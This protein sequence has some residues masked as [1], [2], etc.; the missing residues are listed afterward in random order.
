[1]RTTKFS[2]ALLLVYAVELFM[3]YFLGL[4]SVIPYF[5][6]IPFY[7]FL[8][9]K[10][11]QINILQKIIYFILF[12]IINLIVSFYSIKQSI[13]Y[14]DGSSESVTN[15]LRISALILLINI[16]TFFYASNISLKTRS[17]N[18][19]TG[20]RYL[21]FAIIFLVI[22]L[23]IYCN[24]F[25]EYLLFCYIYFHLITFFSYKD[26]MPYSL[27]TEGKTGLENH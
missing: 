25:K 2:L 21:Y 15:F 20:I 3:I 24:N 17:L 18:Y 6:L 13:N 1:M 16:P 10:L 11:N 23:I 7:P 22:A 19:K 12:Y 5:I 8:L 26:K 9:F 27:T 4:K 14:I